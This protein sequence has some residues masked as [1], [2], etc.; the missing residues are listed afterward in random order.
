MRLPI[1]D[2]F[3]W[4]LYNLLEKAEFVKVPRILTVRSLRNLTSP[5][6]TDFW[7]EVKK[8]KQRRNFSQ[9][10]YHLKK[11]G[12]IKIKNLEGKRGILLTPKGK[13]KALSVRFK[14][15]KKEKRKD[16]KWIMVIFDIP[17]K[18]RKI[19]DL[20]RKNLLVLGYQ[21]LQKSIWVCPYDVFKETEELIRDY[22]IDFYVRIFLIEEIEL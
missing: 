20:F 9:L 5:E 1:T 14:N 4:S 22:L 16:S 6:L 21:R 12:L 13:Q 10:I 8:R 3:L 2:K 19:R 15:I 11:R 18:K 7:Q 17:E